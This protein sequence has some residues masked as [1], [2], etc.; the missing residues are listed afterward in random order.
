MTVSITVV[1]VRLSPLSCVGSI[2]REALSLECAR[3]GFI[4]L[5]GIRKSPR[6]LMVFFSL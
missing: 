5:F 6:Y 2:A 3:Y 4:T 1:K